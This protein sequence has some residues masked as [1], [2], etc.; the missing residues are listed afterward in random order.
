MLFA[1]LSRPMEK[2]DGSDSVQHRYKTQFVPAA[3]VFASLLQNEFAWSSGSGLGGGMSLVGFVFLVGDDAVALVR[4]V[5]R[6]CVV[7]R[8]SRWLSL[9]FSIKSRIAVD[10]LCRFLVGT[11]MLAFFAYFGSTRQYNRRED[12]GCRISNFSCSCSDLV[13]SNRWIPFVSRLNS[14]VNR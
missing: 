12:F 8:C 5:V 1:H 14:W 11:I 10:A 7:V 13:G 2:A 3:L 6:C 4:L 9:S